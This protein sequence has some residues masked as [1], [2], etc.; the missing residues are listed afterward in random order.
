MELKELLRGSLREGPINEL[1]ERGSLA[2]L[3]SQLSAPVRET[4]VTW[5]SPTSPGIGWLL[6]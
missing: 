1:R 4:G 6:C 5:E 3:T 2:S